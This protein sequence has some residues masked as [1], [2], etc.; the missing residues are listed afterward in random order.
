MTS[1]CCGGTVGVP[2]ITDEEFVEQTSRRC[3]ATNR[4]TSDEKRFATTNLGC[5]LARESCNERLA[6]RSR[7]T[8]TRGRT[9]YDSSVIALQ[10][11]GTV[12]VS[13]RR[14][15][16]MLNRA[17]L[18]SLFWT[19]SMLW[20]R[21]AAAQLAPTGNHYA[22]RA[23]DT[24][25]TGPSASGGYATSIPFEFPASR[26]GLPIPVQVVSGTRGFGALGLG[27]DVPL[28]FVHVDSSFVRRR[29]AMGSVVP[30]PAPRQRVT[31]SLL[32][33]SIEMVPYGSDWTGRSAPE[34]R[35]RAVNGTTWKLF[36]GHG[37]TYTFTQDPD[38][39][40]FGG[41]G[42][43]G[44]SGLWLLKTITGPGNA[45]VQLVYA[46]NEVN[47]PNAT[48]PGLAIDLERVRYN[49][50]PSTAGCFKNEVVL[51]YGIPLSQQL[52]SLSLI[53]DR[54]LARDRRLA[55][56]D[57]MSRAQC[58]STPE[59]LRRYSFTHQLDP[60]TKQERLASVQLLGRQ[61]T[62]E[63]ST[64]IPVASYGCAARHQCVVS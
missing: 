36:D 16:D 35:L 23:S 32:G 37:L 1:L 42:G 51:S 39:Q 7:T 17:V 54:M 62:P 45:E 58:A 18:V 3:D 15:L 22:G 48:W 61:G 63:A 29:P 12:S 56:I 19:L 13:A 24:G 50:H 9:L 10:R 43:N 4:C 55:F 46:I 40:L 52:Q 28:S 14:S 2:T 6:P 44:T 34:L 8:R 38:P 5:V 27:W 59:R 57:V 26:G 25:H 21:P 31:V 60:D 64:P 41:T 30:P 20:C 33:R 53:G 11:R 47:I 49:R